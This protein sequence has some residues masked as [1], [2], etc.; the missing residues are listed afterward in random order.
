MITGEEVMK[1]EETQK[2]AERARPRAY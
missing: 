2:V 1:T